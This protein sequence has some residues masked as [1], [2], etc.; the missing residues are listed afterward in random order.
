MIV[1]VSRP[2]LSASACVEAVGAAGHK[3]ERC[4]IYTPAVGENKAR[5]LETPHA[6][7]GRYGGTSKSMP[8]LRRGGASHGRPML[9]CP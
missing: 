2:F 6:P 1:S 7:D 8:P 9:C 5:I 3:C 4:W